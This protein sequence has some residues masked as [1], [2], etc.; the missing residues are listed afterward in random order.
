MH[1][2]DM[3]PAARR[4]MQLQIMDRANLSH[5]ITGFLSLMRSRTMAELADW[6]EI[7]EPKACSLCEFTP[8]TWTPPRWKCSYK[9]IILCPSCGA[10]QWLNSPTEWKLMSPRHTPSNS[11]SLRK[12]ST[13]TIR[14]NEL[15]S[16]KVE[17]AQLG[18]YTRTKNI[19]L[20]NAST[21]N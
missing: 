7:H 5:P 14:K 16:R 10:G 17:E 1:P 8:E 6:M 20:K 4:E 21:P 18:L 13:G 15:L 11:L 12:Q 3:D 19:S 9:W 2:R